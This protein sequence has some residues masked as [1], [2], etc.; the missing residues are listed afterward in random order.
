MTD[1]SDLLVKASGLFDTYP[2]ELIVAGGLV[3]HLYRALPWT[4]TKLAAIRTTEI[5]IA[6]PLKL[7]RNN[8]RT[9]NALLVDG[10]FVEREIP[11]FGP[12][13][14]PVSH[15]HLADESGRYIEFIAQGDGAPVRIP[16]ELYAQGVRDCDLLFHDPIPLTLEA[17][18]RD[19]PATFTV[20]LPQ[21]TTYIL[22]KV[23]AYQQRTDRKKAS[24]DLAG[25][26]D[27]ALLTRPR[28]P[29]AASSLSRLCEDE[30]QVVP[31]LKKRHQQLRALFAAPDADGPLG[32][33]AQLDKATPSPPSPEYIHRV[34]SDW[35]DAHPIPIPVEPAPPIE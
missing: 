12:R 11:G 18:P 4:Q 28:W 31:R 19:G 16:P 27:V 9:P 3:P 34:A 30:P 20:H 17:T 29:E 32:A 7:T 10:G 33:Y 14:L 6:V 25:I 35:L 21:P 8:R 26:F 1:V 15:F 2:D 5:D 23:T 22:Q 24:K 13:D